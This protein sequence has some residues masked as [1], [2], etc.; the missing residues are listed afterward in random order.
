MMVIS[1]FKKENINEV[2]FEYII[3]M[4]EEEKREIMMKEVFKKVKNN[5]N[6]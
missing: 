3:G 4:I 5:E 6:E 2:E 1:V